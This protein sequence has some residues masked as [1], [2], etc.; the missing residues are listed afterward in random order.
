MH[1]CHLEGG[2]KSH[3]RGDS[4]FQANPHAI[5]LGNDASF[6]DEP[7]DV[8]EETSDEPSAADGEAVPSLGAR[9]RIV[10]ALKASKRSCALDG[11]LCMPARFL[12]PSWVHDPNAHLV[13]MAVTRS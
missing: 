9:G 7:L 10:E 8:P 13:A 1:R 5:H 4:S 3:L 6:E 12:G 11:K 2:G